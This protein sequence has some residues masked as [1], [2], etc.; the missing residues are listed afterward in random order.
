MTQSLIKEIENVRGVDLRA[1]AA[2]VLGKEVVIVDA[3]GIVI[4]AETGIGTVTGIVI[5]DGTGDVRGTAIVSVV[6][7]AVDE[8]GHAIVTVGGPGSVAVIGE[9]EDIQ[10]VGH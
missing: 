9:D 2:R 5:E 1:T 4:G 10:G 8:V 7:R 3:I 6:E